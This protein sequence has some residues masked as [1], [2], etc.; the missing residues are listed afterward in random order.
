MALYDEE[1]V[2]E[3]SFDLPERPKTDP[4]LSSDI[5]S[6]S[7]R[8]SHITR[9]EFLIDRSSP[10]KQTR[11]EFVDQEDKIANLFNVTKKRTRSAK[12]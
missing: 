5:Y 1:S 11:G 4:L 2:D 3:E 12:S 8:Y 6:R 9:P 7:L 10:V